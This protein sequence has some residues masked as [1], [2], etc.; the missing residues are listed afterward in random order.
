MMS[1][2]K[3]VT[4]S[5]KHEETLAMRSWL[6]SAIALS[7][8]A[9]F[10]ATAEVPASQDAIVGTW[11]TEKQDSKIE[12]ARNGTTYA[13]KVI[14]LKQPTRDGKPLHDAKNPNHQLRDRPILG[15]E[16]LSGFRYSGDATWSKG[17]IYSPQ[18]G[19]TFPAE[20]SLVSNDRLDIKVKDGIFFKHVAWTRATP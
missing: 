18:T 13:G 11:L 17:A 6:C 8:L 1:K 3:G 2:R 15:L 5:D 14:W 20:L 19:S 4:T 10:G 9:T 16:I 12:I 7:C